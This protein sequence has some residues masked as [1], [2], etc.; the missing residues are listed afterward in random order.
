MAVA[1]EVAASRV[2]GRWRHRRGFLI[3]ACAALSLGAAFASA[4]EPPTSGAAWTWPDFGDDG[5]GFKPPP[6]R[7]G[8]LVAYGREL[9]ARTYAYVGP[10]VKNPAMRYAG[11]NLACRNCHLQDGTKKYGVPFVGTFAVFPQYVARE[12][13]VV[14]L[15][16]RVNGCMQRSMNG[17][18]LPLGSRE[19]RAFVAWIRYL[20]DGVPAGH[21]PQ[22]RG[23][24]P[25][26]MLDRRADPQKGAAVYAEFCAACHQPDG[27]GRRNGV[28][29]DAK[30]Y[31]FPPLWGP[32]SYNVGA[33]MARVIT[34]AEFVH[35]NM[36]SGASWDAPVLSAEQAFDVAA[37]IDSQP[38][39]SMAGLAADYPNRAEKRI[40][41]PYGPY[42]DA[43]SADQHKFGPFGP[44]ERARKTAAANDGQ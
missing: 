38:R 18:P 40:D 26:P 36:P 6:G 39:P 25:I 16:E 15:E 33:G 34:A 9:T 5:S 3:V 14:S 27:K 1:P 19:M 21:P 11:N 17:K 42:D 30:G 22:G 32:D 31:A 7:W 13:R 29:G 4:A 8:A 10:E 23:S 12:G 44:I 43:F 37:Y 35:G 20:S 28:A 2:R 24:A 41:T